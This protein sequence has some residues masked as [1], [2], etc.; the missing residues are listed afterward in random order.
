MIADIRRLSDE[1][2]VGVISTHG[3]WDHVFGNAEFGDVPIWG[4]PVSWQR[5]PSR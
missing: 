2:I 1:P 3:H 4:H 5:R